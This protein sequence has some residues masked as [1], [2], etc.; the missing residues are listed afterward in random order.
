MRDQFGYI[1]N[2]GVSKY[3]GVN[4]H[5]LEN[6][7]QRWRVVVSYNGVRHQLTSD[8]H[9]IELSEAECAS[10]AAYI[11]DVGIPAEKFNVGNLIVNVKTQTIVK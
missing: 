3:Y 8:N 4:L 7:S 5:W 11:K 10:V 6:G 1:N 2:R 9:N